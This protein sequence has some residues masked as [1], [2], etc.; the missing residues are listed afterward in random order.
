MQIDMFGANRAPVVVAYGAGVDSTAMVVELVARGETIDLILFA[1]TGS[2]KAATIAYM[3]MFKAW[4]EATGLRFEIVRYQPKNFKNHPPYRSLIENCLTNGTLPS[5]AFGFSSCSLK[6]KVAPQSAFERN[7]EPAVTAWSQGL[8]IQKLIGYDCSPAD[9]KRYAQREGHTDD[10]YDYR[11]PLREWGWKRDDCIA[12]IQAEGL[13]VPPKS[14]CVMCL[15]TK[16]NELHDFDPEDLRLIVLMEARAAPGLRTTQGL[17]RKAVLGTRGG[18]ARPGAMTDY[19][20]SAKLL[21]A[22]EVDWIISHAP[23]ELIWFQA[24]Q[25]RYPVDRRAPI[26]DWIAAF[27]D[28]FAA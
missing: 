8:K 4:C 9:I 6:W 7:W 26:A 23:T 11:Y 1:D 18:Q 13:A 21:P 3:R 25:S 28:K 12:R 20:L 16:P 22:A 14:A 17:W 27:H 24:Q 10:S 5:I 2:E 19:I 15:A